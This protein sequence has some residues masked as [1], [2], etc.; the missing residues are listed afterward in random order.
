MRRHP[1]IVFSGPP[2]DREARVEG[3]GLEV[4]QVISVYRDCKED[5]DQTLKILSHLS[6]RQVEA[7]LSYYQSYPEEIN[8]LIAENERPAEE[9]QRLYPH[10]GIPK[11]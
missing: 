2:G 10:V 8:R 1:G 7:A 4:W 5:V 3:T 9:W 11:G 6:A